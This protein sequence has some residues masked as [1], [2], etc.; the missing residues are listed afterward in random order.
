M[1]GTWQESGYIAAILIIAVYVPNKEVLILSLM[2][3]ANR[4]NTP[5]GKKG[6]SRQNSAP[7][8][9]H[10]VGLIYSPMSI[11]SNFR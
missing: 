2:I 6:N 5:Y 7:H 10:V 3:I 8:S 1:K 9:A 11:Q 4:Y